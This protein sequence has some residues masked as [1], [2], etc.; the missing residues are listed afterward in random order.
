M[1]RKDQTGA[2]T[3]D[4]IANG[5]EGSVTMDFGDKVLNNKSVTEISFDIEHEKSDLPVLGSVNK[6]H[7]KLGSNGTFSMTM[8]DN[9]TMLREYEQ[10]YQDNS[11]DTF[12]TTTVVQDDPST[13][14]EAQSI[15]YYGCNIDKMTLSQLN[16]ESEALKVEMSG[17]W[18]YFEINRKFEGIPGLIS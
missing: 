18:E 12:F 3:Q 2:L 6:V 16:V 15:S 17:T 9:M 14:L 13:K 5:V 4:Y 1:P 7:K 10:M 8:Y 11:I